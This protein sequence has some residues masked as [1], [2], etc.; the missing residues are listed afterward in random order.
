MPSAPQNF[1]KILSGEIKGKE[2]MK[3]NQQAFDDYNTSALESCSNC[4]RLVLN[5]NKYD[6]RLQT[7]NNLS[8]VIYELFDI[9]LLQFRTFKPEALERHKKGCKVNNSLKPSNAIL[10]ILGR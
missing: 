9:C 8:Y 6:M 4:G 10:R 1:D 7:F 3:L 2:L 5:D